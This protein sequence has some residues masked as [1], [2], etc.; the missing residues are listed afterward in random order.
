MIPY[1]DES[2][3]GFMAGV[4]SQDLRERL[5]GAVSNGQSARSAARLFDI[6]PST[7]AKWMQHW[8]RTGRVPEAQPRGHYRWYLDAHEAW[9]FALI[10]LEPDLTLAEILRRLSDERGGTSS[11][12]ALWRFFD[13][14]KVV[15]KKNRAGRRAE[16]ARRRRGAGSVA[17][18][19]T[20]S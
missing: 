12:N 4:Y 19:S 5:I 8:R 13:R 17:G 2:Q 18:Q 20:P 3:E 16:P 11:I 6:S 7:A 9:L 10:A 1:S 15:F 14:H